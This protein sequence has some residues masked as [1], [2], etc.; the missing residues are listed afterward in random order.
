MLGG[1]EHTA[2]RSDG[3]SDAWTVGAD[4]EPTVLLAI[5]RKRSNFD[6]GTAQIGNHY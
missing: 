4:A 6:A 1:D 3:L 5:R 2:P